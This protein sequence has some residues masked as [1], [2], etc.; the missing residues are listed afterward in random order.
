MSA[1][2][3]HTCIFWSEI[4][5]VNS[6]STMI[7]KHTSY[8]LKTDWISRSTSNVNPNSHSELGLDL[9]NH[10]HFCRFYIHGQLGYLRMYELISDLLFSFRIPFFS[11]GFPFF[12]FGFLGSFLGFFSGTFF[13]IFLVFFGISFRGFLLGGKK[14][15]K[16]SYIIIKNLISVTIFIYF[17]FRK[18]P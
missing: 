18:F 13:G 14:V 5:Y 4:D 7:V 11:F 12:F 1:E 10:F 9:M 16:R 6:G 17:H 3:F 2:H 8:S 15:L